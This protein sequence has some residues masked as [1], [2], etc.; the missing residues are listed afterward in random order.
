MRTDDVARPES[1]RFRFSNGEFSVELKERRYVAYGD[2]SSDAYAVVHGPTQED[3]DVIS[4]LLDAGIA[5]VASE[6]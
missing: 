3:V 5:P 6:G 2:Y 1:A 4:A